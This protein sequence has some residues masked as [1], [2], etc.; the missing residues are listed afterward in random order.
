YILQATPFVHHRAIGIGA[1]ARRA[2]QVPAAIRDRAIDADVAGAGGGEDLLA[3][4]NPV[5]QHFLAVLADGV[6]DTRGW[7]AVAVLQHRIERDA[8]VLFGKVLADGGR[9]E[10]VTVELAEDAVM[11][12]APRQNALALAHHGLEYRPD[13]APEL[14]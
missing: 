5:V 6:V 2:Q 11:I 7:N 4:C 12:R 8:V 1:N 14:D 10:P 3:T 9:G 13:A